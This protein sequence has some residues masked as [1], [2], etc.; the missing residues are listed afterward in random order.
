MGW[1]HRVSGTG[2]LWPVY[3]QTVSHAFP[4]F[5]RDQESRAWSPGDG[6]WGLDVSSCI[7]RW[8]CISASARAQPHLRRCIGVFPGAS[9]SSWVHLHL[10]GRSAP[11]QAHS[12]AATRPKA[13]SVRQRRPPPDSAGV[14]MRRNRLP[15]SSCPCRWALTTAR[16]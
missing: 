11:P 15:A 3:I 8:E 16:A 10:R 4:G 14:G 5:D 7:G 12:S 6:H 1:R 13:P 9:A 2:R